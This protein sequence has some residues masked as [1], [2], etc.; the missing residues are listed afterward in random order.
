MWIDIEQNTDEWLDLRCGKVTGSS[1]ATI[2][3]NY[4]KA[5]GDPAKRYAVNV[6]VERIRGER[7]QGDRYD[8][9]HM[10]AGHVE[11][12]V[13]RMLYEDEYFCEV[14]NGGFFD[15]G[16]TGCSP[17]G[18]VGDNGMVE[19]KSVIPPTHYNCIKRQ[20]F[21]PAYKWQLY[22]NLKESGR[23]WV[24]FISYCEQFAADRRLHVVRV[25]ASDCKEQ[26]D[27][28]DSRLNEFEEL[29]EKVTSDILS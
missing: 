29:V 15:N 2:M 12:P 25:N 16:K 26:F 13:A 10:Q 6:A 18:L 5:F 7:I 3:A 17:D 22:F 28:I 20:S 23:D 27:M 8:N 21:D 19:I 14:T 24:D 4:G 9:A 1:V 11:E